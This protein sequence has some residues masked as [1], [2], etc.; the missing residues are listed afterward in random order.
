M[1]SR[2]NTVITFISSLVILASCASSNGNHSNENVALN[3]APQ[4]IAVNKY[5]R[6]NNFSQG[7]I[8]KLDL[9]IKDSQLSRN[10]LNGLKKLRSNMRK[11]ALKEKFTLNIEKSNVHS[12]ELIQLIYSLNLP[13]KITWGSIY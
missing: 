1:R 13:I 7:A 3:E 5:F 9:Y 8:K 4:D 12:F 2:K 10:E 11:I 6:Y